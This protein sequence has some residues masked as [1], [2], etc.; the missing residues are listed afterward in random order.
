MEDSSKAFPVVETGFAERNGAFSPDGRWVAYRSLESG[1]EEIFVT[2]FP[3]GGAKTQASIGGGTQPRWSRDGK[4]LFYVSTNNDLVAVEV[5]GRGSRFEAKA[6]RIL[7]RANLLYGPRQGFHAYDVDPDG[8][9]FILNTAS[10][11]AQPRAALVV[12]W[13]ADLAK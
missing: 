3:R 7:F 13:D 10:E 1:K 4:T 9:R 12:H 11:V 2:P 8:K 6:P 5:D